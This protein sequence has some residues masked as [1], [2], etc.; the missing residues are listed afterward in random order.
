MI[1]LSGELCSKEL[2]SVAGL[3]GSA[4]VFLGRPLLPNGVVSWM[5]AA[6]ERM[7][8]QRPDLV[9]DRRLRLR[10]MARRWAEWHRCAWNPWN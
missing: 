2:P 10:W 7:K 5:M 8:E 4:P 9:W 6:Q 3:R 1:P